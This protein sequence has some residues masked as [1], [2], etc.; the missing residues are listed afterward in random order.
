M[1]ASASALVGNSQCRRSE[2]FRTIHILS[3]MSNYH[4]K[5]RSTSDIR[6]STCALDSGAGEI[7]I[8]PPIAQ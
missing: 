8:Q 2:G 3:G 7:S 1:Y 6:S 5:D 4:W